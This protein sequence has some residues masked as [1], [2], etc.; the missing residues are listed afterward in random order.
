[1]KAEYTD[2]H[3][4]IEVSNVCCRHQKKSFFGVQRATED[5]Q[6]D[7]AMN[8]NLPELV[9][10]SGDEDSE[11]ENVCVISRAFFLEKKNKC[12]DVLSLQR[13]TEDLPGD[14]GPMPSLVGTEGDTDCED[15]WVSGPDSEDDWVSGPMPSHRVNLQVKYH[16][17]LFFF[18]SMQW[19]D[20][21]AEKYRVRSC[22]SK[23]RKNKGASQKKAGGSA[24]RKQS[25]R[26]RRTFS[27]R[28]PTDENAGGGGGDDRRPPRKNPNGHVHDHP[29]N[30]PKK[31]KNAPKKKP[32][33]H[34]DDDGKEMELPPSRKRRT[35]SLTS[36]SIANVKR[37]RARVGPADSSDQDVSMNDDSD[38]SA[39]STVY[40]SNISSIPKVFMPFV[41]CE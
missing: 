28:P 36:Q 22:A 2:A 1:M 12:F 9:Q 34:F 33:Q 17:F 27:D 40:T 24:P 30:E 39:A 21:Q 18:S 32:V 37:K 35:R 29:S 19:L 31:K 20:M 11:Q 23:S 16:F 14:W 8:E 38:A 6:S 26:R 3:W 25:E 13:A 4:N 15:D 41:C 10:T 7:E 5:R